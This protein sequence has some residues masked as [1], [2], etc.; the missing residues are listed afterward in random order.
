MILAVSLGAFGAHALKTVLSYQQLQTWNTA[1]EYQFYHA[2]GLI[3]LG[4]WSEKTTLQRLNVFAGSFLILGTLLFSGSLYLLALTGVTKLGM[5]T[6]F[7]G[8]FF[9]SGWLLWLLSAAKKAD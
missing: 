6:P 9:I 2:L 3:G 4:I 8:V 5:V 1:V 7:G